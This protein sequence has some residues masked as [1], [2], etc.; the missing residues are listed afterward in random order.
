M[1][2]PRIYIGTAQSEEG[3][4]VSLLTCPEKADPYLFRQAVLRRCQ[5]LGAARF[6]IWE[7]GQSDWWGLVESQLIFQG[8]V[9]N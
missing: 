4:I 8:K 3:E 2:Q 6:Y 7:V 9:R 1:N 5:E